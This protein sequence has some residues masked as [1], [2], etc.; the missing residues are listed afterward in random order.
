MDNTIKNITIGHTERLNKPVGYTMLANLVNIVPFCLSIEAINIIFRSFDGSGTAL[1]T[2]RLWLLSAVLVVYMAVMAVAERAAY[3]ANFRGAYEMSAAGRISLAEHLRKLSLGFLSRHDPGDL[4]SMLIT[5]FTMAETGISHHLPQLMGALVMPVLAFLSL[6]FIDWRMSIAMF[7]ALPMAV[8]ILWCS[9]YVQTRLSGKQI[10]AKINAGNR[11]E[12]YLQGIRVMKAYNLLGPRFVRLRNAFADLRRA[13]IR[14]ETLLGPFVLLSITL[15][16][17]GLTLMVLCGTY[18]LLGGNLSVLTFVMFLVVGSRVFDPLTSA[19]TNFAEFRYFSIAGG[20]ILS[21]MNIPE[22]RGSRKAPQSGDIIFEHVSFGYQDKMVLNDISLTLSCN[23]LT[24]LVGPSGSGK[25]TLM[26]LCARF[27]DPYKGRVLFDGV[28]MSEIEPEL[29]MERI[30]MVFQDVYLFQD[31]IRNNIRFGRSDATD[32]DIVTAAQ[33]A[34]CHDFIMRLPN[35]YDSMVGEGGCTL[36]GGE[37]QRLS[38]ARA[39][40]KNAQ[41]VLLDEA[42]AS[43]DPEN[44]VE[45]QQAIDMLIKGRTVIVIAHRLKTVCNA[46]NIVVLNGGSIVEQGRHEALLAN[47]GLYARLWNI[48]QETA[49]WTL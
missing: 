40:L 49:G 33:K 13:C 15:V 48:Q 18:L 21:L 46:D 27:Y 11:L 23:S 4:S 24:A 30:S 47:E 45:V 25:S 37:K 39:I 44:E 17:A 2:S 3:R 35:G 12:E 32:E 26:K 36:S 28:P 16:R 42:T 31:T 7:V 34:C 43:L 19:L 10:A 14:Q 9:T 29:L 22:M 41:I 38:I 6:L 5:D 8:L 1:D 20:R